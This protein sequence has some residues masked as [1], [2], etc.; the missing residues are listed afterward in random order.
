[1]EFPPGFEPSSRSLVLLGC[2]LSTFQSSYSS[3]VE[4]MGNSICATPSLPDDL[5]DIQFALENALYTSTKAALFEYY[6]DVLKEELTK[7]FY[8][9]MKNA[10]NKVNTTSHF[11]SWLHM[12]YARNHKGLLAFC[13]AYPQ[14]SCHFV[15]T[16]YGLLCKT[17]EKMSP[18]LIASHG[19][20]SRW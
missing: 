15:G 17:V 13:I 9:S 14:P 19:A 4:D 3:K 8:L 16:S 18:I 2:S 10:K 12:L 20:F 1:M 5:T 6:E 7:L 11:S